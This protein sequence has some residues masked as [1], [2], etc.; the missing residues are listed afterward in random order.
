MNGGGD[1]ADVKPRDGDGI[2]AISFEAVPAYRYIPAGFVLNDPTQSDSAAWRLHL[3]PVMARYAPPYAKTLVPLT[4]QKA[5]FKRGD[6]AI[7]VMS[8]ET[9]GTVGMDGGGAMNAALVV[10]PGGREPRDYAAVRDNAPPTVERKPD[11]GPQ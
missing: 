4:H 11:N 7:V 9:K 3:P 8:Y 2:T 6:S 10:T 5:V 1:R